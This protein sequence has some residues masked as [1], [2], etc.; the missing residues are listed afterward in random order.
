MPRKAKSETTTKK[1]KEVKVQET[2]EQQFQVEDIMSWDDEKCAEM[3][4]QIRFPVKAY[5]DILREGAAKSQSLQNITGILLRGEMTGYMIECPECHQQYQVSSGDLNR[6]TE[7]TCKCGKAF[8]ETEN[9]KGIAT[10]IAGLKKE[11]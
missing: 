3:D 8:K 10:D 6:D 2:K 11:N 1:V 4:K 7:V 9:I 5:R